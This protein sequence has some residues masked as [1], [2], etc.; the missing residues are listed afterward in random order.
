MLVEP[1][2]HEDMTEEQ[3]AERDTR[4]H[5]CE[6]WCKPCAVKGTGGIAMAEVA[7]ASPDGEITPELYRRFLQ[8]TDERGQPM[9]N[10]YREWSKLVRSTRIAIGMTQAELADAAGINLA[11][12]KFIEVCLHVSRASTI[13][14]VSKVLKLDESKTAAAMASSRITD[15]RSARLLEQHYERHMHCAK[16]KGTGEIPDTSDR[17]GGSRLCDGQE[18]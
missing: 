9:T 6:C 8:I 2:P 5:T 16:C 4:L 3:A 14:A 13:A 15:T 12:V 1:S 7:E 17:M 18:T 10:A 11:T